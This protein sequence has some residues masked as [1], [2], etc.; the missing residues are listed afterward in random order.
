MGSFQAGGRDLRGDYRLEDSLLAR[1][2]FRLSL[3][4]MSCL[5]F[6]IIILTSNEP[7]RRFNDS[8]KY[9]IASS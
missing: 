4:T 6:A 2:C 8:S 9:M 7:G 1:S 3:D 5:C